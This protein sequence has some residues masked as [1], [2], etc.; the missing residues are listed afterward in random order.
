MPVFREMRRKEKQISEEDAVKMLADAPYL[1]LSVALADGYPYNIPLNH[2]YAG[3]KIYF[4]SA[5]E[6]QKVDAFKEQSRVCLSVVDECEIAADR[7][8]T[9]FRSAVAF[10][11]ISAVEDITEKRSA[12]SEIIKKFS[13]GFIESGNAY[14]DKLFDKTAVYRVDIDHITGKQSR[15]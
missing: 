14:I 7:F 11:R 12:L 4:H 13:P 9:N 3:G 6:G 15:K 8:S 10:G 1:T 5:K 2:V